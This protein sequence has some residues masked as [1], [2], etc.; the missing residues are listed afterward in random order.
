MK[1]TIIVTGLG[2]GDE[3]KGSI[4]DY[5]C[6]TLPVHTVI[7]HNGG[8]QAAHNVVLPDGR[9]HTFAQ[10]GA[11]TLVPGVRT[12]L[13]Q[14]MYVNPANLLNENQGLIQFGIHDAMYR[15]TIHEDAP[16]ITP[17]HVAANQL[18]EIA[19]GEGRHGSCGQGVGETHVDYMANEPLRARD[20][21]SRDVLWR[22]LR[23]IHERVGAQVQAV[24]DVAPEISHLFTSDAMF[25]QIISEYRLI[26]EKIDS[27]V[28]DDYVE[29]LFDDGVVVFEG[30]QGMLL[31][32]WYGFYPHTTWSR[33]GV[34]NAYEII[35]DGYNAPVMRLG[36][37]RAYAT[38]HGAGPLPTEDEF[39]SHRIP[40]PRNPENPWQRNFRVGYT[41]LPLLRYAA[42][43]LGRVDALAVTCLDHVAGR[44]SWPVNFGYT[45]VTGPIPT[46]GADVDH[47]EM[48]RVQSAVTR[49]LFQAQ[50]AYESF[51]LATT[52]GMTALLEEITRAADAPILITSHGPTAADKHSHLPS[53]IYTRA[54]EELAV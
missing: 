5:L 12:H 6:R 2:F 20:L 42:H 24:W 36:I 23:E 19:R 37:T 7:R 50:P 15:M 34:D 10:F 11:G 17:Y 39:L 54:E 52:T 30:A 21:T 16:I 4:V 33:T 47:A 53:Y 31:D 28:G 49:A 1:E 45:N 32:Q 18:R 46:V 14:F 40:D 27:I 35:P 9:W 13:S 22:K 38:R 51:N 41:D 26:P 8:A 48:V 43:V 44:R 29:S 25:D 3:G